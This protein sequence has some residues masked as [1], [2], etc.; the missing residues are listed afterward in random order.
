MRDKMRDK[1]GRDKNPGKIRPDVTKPLRVL[2]RSDAP[3]GMQRKAAE[4]LGFLWLKPATF[5]GVTKCVTKV[6]MSRFDLCHAT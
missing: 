4:V 6:F 2:S 5:Q 3:I 1:N